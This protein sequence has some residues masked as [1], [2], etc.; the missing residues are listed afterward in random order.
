MV[1]PCG[2]FISGECSKFWVVLYD[3]G[4]GVD[5]NL[6]REKVV[7]PLISLILKL[8]SLF[9]RKFGVSMINSGFWR[10]NPPVMLCLKALATCSI[11]Y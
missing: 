8:R 2:E 4:R 9:S 10:F 6:V 7:M 11:L 3:I 5:D 1:I